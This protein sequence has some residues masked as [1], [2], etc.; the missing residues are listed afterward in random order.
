MSVESNS[1]MYCDEDDFYFDSHKKIKSKQLSFSKPTVEKARLNVLRKV[2]Q[3]P[4]SK[5]S[6]EII[7]KL[8][9]NHKVKDIV[10]VLRI[11]KK[12]VTIHARANIENKIFEKLD[13]TDSI[14]IKVFYDINSVNKEMIAY[15][16]NIHD[17][18]K[19]P[20]TKSYPS[21]ME[22]DKNF[23]SKQMIL[24]QVNNVV[25]M[26]MMEG[27][28]TITQVLEKNPGQI[29]GIFDE[30]LGFLADVLERDCTFWSDELC[31]VKNIV[32]WNDMWIF[33]NV[34][35]FSNRD[36]FKKNLINLFELFRSFEMTLQQLEK[37]FLNYFNSSHLWSSKGTIYSALLDEYFYNEVVAR[38]SPRRFIK[39]K[40][41]KQPKICKK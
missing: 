35:T 17:E 29:V 2:Q 28:K 13:G 16:R 27:S 23:L 39:C 6:I 22:T 24:L 14:V 31:G 9:I 15:S 19:E 41:P 38:R 30:I 11:G 18:I 37:C 25:L 5:N 26:R 4:I 21:R 10:K 3:L 36:N 20:S 12:S 1:D 40:F 33:L 32:F 8:V 34:G 7:S